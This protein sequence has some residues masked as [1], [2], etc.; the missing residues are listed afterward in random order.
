MSEDDNNAGQ[1]EQTPTGDK[2]AELQQKLDEALEQISRL[3]GTQSAND[4]A[5]TELRT[6]K[7]K[8]EADVAA[9]QAKIDESTAAL[10]EATNKATQLEEQN[11]DLPQLKSKVEALEAEKKRLETV[12]QYAATT[13]AIGLLVQANALPQADTPE[14]FESALKVISDGLGNIGAVGAV[15]ALKN[16]KIPVKPANNTVTAQDLY[17][18]GVQMILRQQEGGLDKVAKA[19]EMLK[20]K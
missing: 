5:L 3:K 2:T 19:L 12:A 14:E 18:Q 4:R 9:L 13:P 17:D 20:Q 8:L 16:A 10:G 1:G 11:A 6:T 7:T 15:D